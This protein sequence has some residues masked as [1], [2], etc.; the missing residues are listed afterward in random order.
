MVKEIK[1]TGEVIVPPIGWVSDISSVAQ[2]GMTPVFV[3][4]S[5][6]N[7]NITAENIKAAINENTK[8]ILPVH[9]YGRVC[10]MPK[11]QELADKYNL[12]VIEDG[13]QNFGSILNGK[14]SLNIA[15]ISCTSFFPS[16]NGVLH[17][18]P[19]NLQSVVNWNYYDVFDVQKHQKYYQ[20]QHSNTCKSTKM[21]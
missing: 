5:L 8:A 6:N 13:A 4:V 2:L 17:R 1:G 7:F 10:N 19:T 9:L 20:D 16:K 11:I 15:D 21:F 3:D 14:S 12:I 18:D